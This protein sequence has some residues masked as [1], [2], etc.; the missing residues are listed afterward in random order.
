MAR[1]P[2]QRRAGGELAEYYRGLLEEQADSGLSV[3]EFAE[4]V[5]VSAATLY[6]WRRR[7]RDDPGLPGA[8]LVQVAV[9]ETSHGGGTLI[10]RV[11]E[12]YEVE[13]GAGFDAD[14]LRRLLAVLDRC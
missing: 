1:R 11:G 5:G 9:S 7:L 8:R 10:L 6:S 2:T 4:E 14:T 3:T 12:E 13:L